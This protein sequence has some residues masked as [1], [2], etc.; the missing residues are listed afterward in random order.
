LEVAL[1][2]AF[3]GEET[4]AMG[5][6]PTGAA[7]ENP[8]AAPTA[9]SAAADE[10]PALKKR[11]LRDGTKQAQVIDLLKRPEGATLQHIMEATGWQM[12]TARSV[13]SRT[14]QKDLGIALVSE[15]A[16]GNDRIYRVNA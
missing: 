12:H 6:A 11:K 7:I 1:F 2:E 15:K 10:Q 5:S 9:E 14:I 8:E 3:G 4:L 16:G 13:L